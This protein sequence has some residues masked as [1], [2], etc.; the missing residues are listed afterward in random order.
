MLSFAYSAA[1]LFVMPTRTEAFGQVVTEA[2]ACG[3]PVVAFDVGGIPDIVR[4]G[5]TG[6]LAP[7]EDV[8][9]L[10]QAILDLLEDDELR[11]HMATECR[12]V[13]E[14]EYDLNLQARRYVVLYE[15]L[16]EMATRHRRDASSA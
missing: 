9:A 11:A 5:R 10:R 7:P 16:M 3:T 6:L 1:D 4:P 12:H 14:V 2:M 13:A 15:E 8:R